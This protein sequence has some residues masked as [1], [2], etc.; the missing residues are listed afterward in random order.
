MTNEEFDACELPRRITFRQSEAARQVLVL[1]LSI[2][3]AAYAV[4]L[5][6]PEGEASIQAAINT[7]VKAHSNAI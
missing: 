5:D 1:G 7:I 3:T 6:T 4:A 2:K